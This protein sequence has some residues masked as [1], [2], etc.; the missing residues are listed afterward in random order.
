MHTLSTAP[1]HI[2]SHMR[3]HTAGHTCDGRAYKC[4][5]DRRQQ[6]IYSTKHTGSSQEGLEHPR[7]DTRGTESCIS[8]AFCTSKLTKMHQKDGCKAFGN[9]KLLME[10]AP[11]LIYCNDKGS[12]QEHLQ[13]L[14]PCLVSHHCH[15]QNYPRCETYSLCLWSLWRCDEGAGGSVTNTNCDGTCSRTLKQFRYE[16][17]ELSGAV[18]SLLLKQALVIKK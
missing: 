13:T 8:Q 12:T 5:R 4:Q 6:N 10:E 15:V 14:V 16:I 9:F 18:C 17:T 11:D 2:S 1:L 7:R 3:Q